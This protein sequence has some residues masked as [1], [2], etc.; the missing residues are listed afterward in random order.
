M[1]ESNKTI[2]TKNTIIQMLED[3]VKEQKMDLERI[4]VQLA[5]GATQKPS[6]DSAELLEQLQKECQRVLQQALIQ[7]GN[8]ASDLASKDALLAQEDSCT[9]SGPSSFLQ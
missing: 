8:F 1:Q 3:K 6:D 2:E 5:I 9:G 4:N 7:K